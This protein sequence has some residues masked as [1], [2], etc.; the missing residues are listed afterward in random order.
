MADPCCDRIIGGEIYI[1]V[2]DRV[3]EA[4]GDVE[5]DPTR[6]EREAN[7]TANG[8]FYAIARAVPQMARITFANFCGD[9]DP[10]QMWD[11]ACDMDITIVEKTR[12]IRHLFTRA[13]VVGKPTQNLSTGQVS[14]MKIATDQYSRA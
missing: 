6:V 1:T 11:I 4:I 9:S 12:G 5:I 14:G 13:S 7:A 10:M 2:G 8:R 3:F